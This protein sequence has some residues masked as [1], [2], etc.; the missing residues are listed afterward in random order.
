MKKNKSI[1]ISS[2][3]LLFLMAY[4][5]VTVLTMS[6]C[7]SDD[8]EAGALKED[9]WLHPY[10]TSSYD[11]ILQM[12]FYNKNHVYLLFNDTLKKVRVGTN[13]DGSPFYN[14][15]DVK[16]NYKLTGNNGGQEEVF[17][18]NYLSSDTDKKTGTEFVQNQ[19][20]P[21]LG[22]SLFPFSILIVDKINYYVSNASTYYEMTLTNPSVYTGSRC[23]AIALENIV[24]MTSDQ[25]VIYQKTILKSIINAQ[26]QSLPSS[27]F[28]DFYAYCNAYY[29]TYAMNDDAT[30]FFK[31]YP[32][33]YDLGLLDGGYYSY[34]AP[35]GFPIYNIKAKSYDLTDYTNAV[36]DY[37]DES[38]KAKYGQYPIVMAKFNLLKKI[39]SEIGVIF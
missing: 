29:S 22:G 35:Y 24:N 13:P 11:Q 19:I 21:H 37:T 1:S 30:A 16:L 34:G 23:T 7:S 20:L 39:F 17:Q 33:P 9:E 15:E 3:S 4:I 6:S 8:V 38:F 12:N 25:Q 28:D 2:K 36:F 14:Y 18:F 31:K 5:I 27:T 10:G 32:T 26:L